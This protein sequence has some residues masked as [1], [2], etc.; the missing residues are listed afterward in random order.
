MAARISPG[1]DKC[2]QKLSEIVPISTPFTLFVT[3][4]QLC[5]FRCAYCTQS[6]SGERKEE[7]DF[8]SQ[9]LDYGLF[10]N[11]AG[12]AS[13]FP[14]KFK[15]VLLTGLGE[16]LMNPR[17]PEMVAALRNL[18][19]ADHY[20]VFTNASLLTPRLSDE[21]LHSGLT[22]LRISIQGV[23][24]RKY[25][26]ITG[27]DVDVEGLI[28]N[29]AYFFHHR[30][31][32]RVYLKIMDACLEGGDEE[33]FFSLFGGICDDIFIEHLV[34]AQPS[35]G[36]YDGRADNVRTFYGEPSETREV[37]PYMFYTLQT[38][39]VGNVFPCPP[40]GLPLKFSLGNVLD[41][42][43]FDIWRGERLRRLRLAH[44][45]G[46][47]EEIEPCRRCSCYR[48]FTPQEDN[49][50]GNP[51]EIIERMIAEA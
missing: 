28:E 2:R 48:S 15:R 46:R 39:A 26:E 49:L 16:P 40:L 41:T 37:C 29:I 36:D 33:R 12:Q 17:I 10:L 14:G 45:T 43:L 3:P 51:E 1:Y 27:R 11:I 19:V 32:C 34:K 7:I 21:L 8:R 47:R 4:S 13:E 25:E 6:L 23:T 30:K 18:G 9:L 31:A 42:P 24:K 38:D 5:N 44:L 20:E 22:C 35:M 50:D